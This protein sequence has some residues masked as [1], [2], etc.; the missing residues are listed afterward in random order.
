MTPDSPVTARV[1]HRFSQPAERVFAAWLDPALIGQWMF[2]P[3]LRDEEIVSLKLEARVGGR[4]SFVVRR[5]GQELD[6]AGEYLE[7]D[8]PRRL[9]LTWG[10]REERDPSRLVL[11]FEPQAD[12]CEVTL[13]HEMRAEWADFVGQSEAAWAR[14]LR[15]LD[16]TLS[17]VPLP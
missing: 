3:H 14:M 16:A 6:H 11:D 15:T 9:V 5:Q 12:G 7:L 1:S 17:G 10:L 13:R 8:R 4:Y 2:G